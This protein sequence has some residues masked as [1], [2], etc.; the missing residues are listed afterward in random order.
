MHS[1]LKLIYT[2][3]VN[4]CEY[5]S[6]QSHIMGMSICFLKS[7]YLGRGLFH[8]IL[9]D[10]THILIYSLVVIIIRYSY[11]LSTLEGYNFAITLP[12]MSYFE[13]SLL[14]F[15]S[16]IFLPPS[17]PSSFFPFLFLHF[18]LTSFLIFSQLTK[19]MVTTSPT[20]SSC[21]RLHASISH[22]EFLIVLI[23]SF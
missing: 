14:Y 1:H 17:P 7:T 23:G 12:V 9:G 19:H 5:H 10:D 20:S 13:L 18:S 4:F 11:S 16:F 8:S 21:A 22:I 15:E 2:C 3:M 6:S